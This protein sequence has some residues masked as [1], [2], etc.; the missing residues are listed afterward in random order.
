MQSS[1][2]INGSASN[3]LR[4]V[5]LQGSD[6]LTYSSLKQL[7]CRGLRNGGWARLEIAEKGLFRCALWIAKARNK[8]TNTRLMV[9]VLRIAL[10]L[11]KGF[12][13]RIVKAG[14]ARAAIMLE[15]YARPGGVFSWAPR[16]REWL[17]DPRYLLYLGVLEVNA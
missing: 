12:Q 1:A 17:H 4:T 6:S 5:A 9:H 7:K 14:K 10:K 3:W 11:F 16:M 2:Y 13:S 8:I 15:T